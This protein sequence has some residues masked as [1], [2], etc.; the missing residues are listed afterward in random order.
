MSNWFKHRRQGRCLASQLLRISASM[1]IEAT[2]ALVMAAMLLLTLLTST[3][4]ALELPHSAQSVAAKPTAVNSAASKTLHVALVSAEASL[5]PALASDVQS[6]SITE[7]I[8]DAMLSYDYLARP[9][10][11]QPNTLSAMPEVSR[12]GLRYLFK[13]KPGIWFTPDPAFKGKKRELTAQD[14]VYSLLR[15]RD[16]ALKSPWQFLVDGKFLGDDSPKS[17]GA[18]IVG[19][20]ALDRY[21]LQ[22]L[23]KQAD[24][25]LLFQL[26]MPATAAVAREV[27]DAYPEQSGNH[28]VGTGPF[29]MGQWQRSFKIEL[30]ANPYYQHRF[31]TLALTDTALAQQLHGKKL[32]LVDRIEI[33]IM[34]ELQS[35][36]LGVMR[37]EVDYHEQLPPALSEMVLVPR[38]SGA[39]HLKPEFIRSGLQLALSAPMQTYYMWMNMEDSMVGGYTPDKIALRRAIAMSY[40]SREDIQLLEQGLALPAQSPLPPNVRGYDPSYRSPVPF[41]PVLANA[42][43]D[44]FGYRNKAGWRTM[45]D[46]SALQ[47]EMYSLASTTGRIRDEVWRKNLTQLGIRIRFKTEKQAD[48]L[49]A[50]RQ[51]K[52]QMAEANWIADYPDGDNFYQLLWSGNCGGPNYARFAL[53]A[54]DQLYLQS[55]QLADSPERQ[56]LYHDMDQLIHAYNP[57]ILRIHPLSA[58]IWQPWLKNYKRHP[59]MLTNWRYLDVI[60]HTGSTNMAAH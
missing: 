14:Y 31:S 38:S 26:A 33:V 29:K 7:N 44:Q 17:T 23:L 10:R 15:L 45:P 1:L 59:V 54:Y 56:H 37:G 18:T 28:P 60:Q 24:P 40:D 12:D 11:L 32:P 43:L 52:V 3:Q 4:A 19:L 20:K 58:D 5:D 2:V 42:L 39:P 35:R 36:M 34:E 50:A 48:I 16:P 55:R 8:F 6:L 49:K 9:V 51:G 53:P 21:T 25:N 13:I 46:G 30:I 41:N 57:W 27:I 22:L 47:L